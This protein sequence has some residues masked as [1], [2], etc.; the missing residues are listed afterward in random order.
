MVMQSARKLVIPSMAFQ[1]QN[2]IKLK[3]KGGV[4]NLSNI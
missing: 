4:T 3:L 1:S 2:K